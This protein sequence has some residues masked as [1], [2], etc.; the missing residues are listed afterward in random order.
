VVFVVVIFLLLVVIFAVQ[1][2]QMVAINFLVWSFSSNQ[3]LIVLGSASIGLMAGALW[4]WLKGV[5]VKRQVKDLS[6]S[7]E[8]AERKVS[9][10]ERALSEE[11]DKTRRLLETREKEE[12]AFTRVDE[13]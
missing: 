1:N 10:L 7:L 2:A 4:S 8:E 3:A 9:S 6:K 13:P 11:M 12:K 5:P